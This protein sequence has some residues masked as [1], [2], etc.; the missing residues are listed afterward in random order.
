MCKKIGEREG[1]REGG[2]KRG[3]EERKEEQM[4]KSARKKE[5]V[6]FRA[7]ELDLL[8]CKSLEVGVGGT[9]S[10]LYPEGLY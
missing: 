10:H 6:I 7:S 3:E 2:K 4:L 8:Y 9:V 1:R 5:K